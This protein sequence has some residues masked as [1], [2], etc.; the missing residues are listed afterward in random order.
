MRIRTRLFPE[1]DGETRFTAAAARGLIGQR[2]DHVL[3]DGSRMQVEVLDAAIEDGWVVV[4]FDL[5]EGP[6]LERTR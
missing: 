4:E 1:F 3:P 2:P 5:P 6:P